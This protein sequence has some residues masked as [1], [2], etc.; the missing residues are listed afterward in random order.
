MQVYVHRDGQNLGPYSIGQLRPYLQAGNF[1]GDDLACLDGVNWVALKD[2]P[3]NDRKTS[4][5]ARKQELPPKNQFQNQQKNLHPSC[6]GF[7]VCFPLRPFRLFW[8]EERK[9]CPRNFPPYCTRASRYYIP[10]NCGTSS[11]GEEN[12]LEN[13]KTYAKHGVP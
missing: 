6:C 7:P 5:P 11:P 8:V 13:S 2:V 12:L 10:T 1:T 9:F 3:G 4:K